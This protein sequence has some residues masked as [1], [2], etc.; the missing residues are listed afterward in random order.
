MLFFVCV[1]VCMCECVYVCVYKVLIPGPTALAD[2]AERTSTEQGLLGVIIYI[3]HF[4]SIHDE[5][6]CKCAPEL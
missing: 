2:L 3:A 1:C 5:L 6:K 4:F